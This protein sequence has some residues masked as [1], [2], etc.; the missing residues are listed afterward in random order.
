MKLYKVEYTSL[1]SGSL[2]PTW[3]PEGWSVYC[4]ERWGERRDFWWPSTKRLYQSRSGARDR[5]ALIEYWGATAEIVESE[6]V[7]WLTPDVK[8]A[9]RRAE[10]LTELATLDAA[11]LADLDAE[12]KRAVDEDEWVQR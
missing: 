2:D 10:L 7:V 1:P 9:R 11:D 12:V 3:E 8:R 4:E 5:A 6:P